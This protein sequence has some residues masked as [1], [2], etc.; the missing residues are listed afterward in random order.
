MKTG[1]SAG[2]WEKY[3]D[4]YSGYFMHI[5][6]PSSVILLHTEDFQKINGFDEDYKGHGFEDFDFMI[7][8]WRANGWQEVTE[9]DI[10]LHEAYRAPMLSHGFRGKLAR[11]SIPATLD[12]VVAFHIHHLISG[13][14]KYY[15]SRN[16]NLQIFKKKM[17]HICAKGG[18]GIFQQIQ[19]N[20]SNFFL[21]CERKNKNPSRYE[22]L[23]DATPAHMRDRYSLH[24]IFR[25][26][27]Y[28]FSR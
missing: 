15:Q 10:D 21:A 23:F 22:R 20:I 1:D 3:L 13:K 6:M 24:R 26:M 17:S 12:D 2:L 18:G 9:N 25:Q 4:F 8:L 5:A 7:R 27:K 11:L 19:D 14:E 16:D 28:I